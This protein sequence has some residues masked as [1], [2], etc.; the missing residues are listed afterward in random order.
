MSD[1]VYEVPADF[2]A[3]ANITDAQYQE[4]YQRSIDD[5]EGFWGEQATEYLSWFKTWDKTLDWSFGEDDLHIE[6]FKGG[7]LNVSY[8]CLDRHLESRGDQ[9][10]ILWEADDPGHDKKI[11][12]RELHADVNKF[13]NVLKS[14]GVKK[15]DRVSIYMPM[16]PE[17]VV[18]MLACTRIGAVHSI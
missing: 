2:A 7:K 16:I 10:A 4:M 6:W 5:P 14:R 1:K 15:G 9:T 18:A 11:S 8:N 3:Q 13:A 12:Y 17:A